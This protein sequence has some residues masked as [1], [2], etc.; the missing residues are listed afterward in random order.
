MYNPTQR[1]EMPKGKTITAFGE[2]GDRESTSPSRKEDRVSS[3]NPDV[4]KRDT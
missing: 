1:L 4:S 2:P 3:H